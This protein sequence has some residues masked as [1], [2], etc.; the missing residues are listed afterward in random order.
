MWQI[1][2]ARVGRRSIRLGRH[3]RRRRRR[4]WLGRSRRP[5][6]VVYISAS[7]WRCSRLP[8]CQVAGWDRVLSGEHRAVTHSRAGAVV[9]RPVP[10]ISYRSIWA[11]QWD[12]QWRRHE[13]RYAQELRHDCGRRKQRE[14]IPPPDNDATGA[15]STPALTPRDVCP[16]DINEDVSGLFAFTQQS[17]TESSAQCRT[18]V[19]AEWRDVFTDRGCSCLW[20]LRLDSTADIA[21]YCSTNVSLV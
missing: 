9:A 15:P 5:D 20:S 6:P 18:T 11:Y 7:R 19:R 14:E 13:L 12:R 10:M 8:Q 17:L 3:R 4:R 2:C 21:R 1:S 16:L